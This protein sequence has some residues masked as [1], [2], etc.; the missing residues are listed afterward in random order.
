MRWVNGRSSPCMTSISSVAVL[1]MAAV[2]HAALVA[3]SAQP[4]GAT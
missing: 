3:R 4:H 1:D 2:A